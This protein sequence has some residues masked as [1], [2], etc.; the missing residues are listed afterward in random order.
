MQ[1]RRKLARDKQ[2]IEEQLTR[3][4]MEKVSGKLKS[5]ALRQHA[6]I[7]ETK[8]IGDQHRIKK[9][10]S[11][12]LL[13]SLKLAANTQ[14]DLQQAAEQLAGEL[15]KTEII[16]LAVRGAA[17]NMEQAAEQLQARKTGNTTL[18]FQQAAHRRLRDLI[19]AIQADNEVKPE[20]NPR[21]GGGG[22]SNNQD[23]LNS[24]IISQLT[25][26]RVLKTLQTEIL[27][28][29]VALDKQRRPET[30]LSAAEQ[31]ELK[32][33]TEEQARLTELTRII[34]RTLQRK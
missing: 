13:K 6:L 5:L 18:Q 24:E 1:S 33:L 30:P 28:R 32:H 25:Q 17:N 29:T 10:W 23:D 8:R 20:G 12:G 9:R 7:S 15:S 22:A 14:H 31:Q 4:L 19:T 26:L 27:T 16:A 21:T 2:R 34:M 3:E 11:R